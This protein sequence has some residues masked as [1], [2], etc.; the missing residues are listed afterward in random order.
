MMNESYRILFGTGLALLLG[1]V[2]AQTGGD[3]HYPSP[4]K[5]SKS[6]EVQSPEQSA[7][8]STYSASP[9]P[10]PPTTEK[11]YGQSS[12]QAE[13]SDETGTQLHAQ[14][15]AKHAH[16]AAKRASRPAPVATR[17]E[18]TYRQALRHCVKEQDQDQRDSC[19]DNAI[20]QFQ[21]NG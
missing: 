10:S 15:H 16:H 18:T 4:D 3:T 17:G 7:A 14:K 13:A 21:R 11:M 5:A 19:L 12:A 2:D 8:T 6:T 9:E 1:A 20:E